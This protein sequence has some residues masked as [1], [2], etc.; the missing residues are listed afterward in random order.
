MIE[1]HTVASSAINRN[2]YD[3]DSLLL[4]V[5]FKDSTPQYVYRGVPMVI[6]KTFLNAPSKG[7]YYHNFIKDRFSF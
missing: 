2:G 7:S 5:D 1:W 4:Y 6:F 3:K